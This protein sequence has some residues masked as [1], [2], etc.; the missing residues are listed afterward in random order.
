MFEQFFTANDVDLFGASHPGH[1]IAVTPPF[2][3][4]LSLSHLSTAAGDALLPS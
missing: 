4:L 1:R 3:E 2:L